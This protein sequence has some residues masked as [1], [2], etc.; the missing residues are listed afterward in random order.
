M[1]GTYMYICTFIQYVYSQQDAFST[2]FA[3]VMDAQQ[4][5]EAR[6]SRRR[7]RE[8][9]NRASESAEQRQ[10]R[11]VRRRVRDRARCVAQSAAQ[12]ETAL[13][14]GRERLTNETTES[15]ELRV[16]GMRL[17]RPSETQE[18]REAHLQ[19]MR[20][21][22]ASETPDE[23]EARLQQMRLNQEGRL[24]NESQEERE[25]RLQ[26]MRLNQEGR[27][28][29]ES[30]EERES[31]LQ[32]MRLNQEGRL[33][34]ESQEEREARLQQ[35]RL[36]Q[37]GRVANESQEERE[38]RLQ[39]MSLYRQCRL[40][41]EPPEDA[42]RRRKPGDQQP[43]EIVLTS[44]TK[45][46]ASPKKFASRAGPSTPNKLTLKNI[47][48][49]A[50][51]QSVTVVAKV[52]KAAPPQTIKTKD[53]R[54]M[55]KQDCSIGDCDR[56]IHVVSWEKDVGSLAEGSSYKLVNVSVHIYDDLRYLSVG[57]NCEIVRIDQ[58]GEVVEDDADEDQ[59]C[60]GNY[61]VEGDIDD[62]FYCDEYFGCT[63]CNKKLAVNDAIG[64]CSKCG[65]TVKIKKALKCAN[66]C[67]LVCDKNSTSHNL[68]LFNEVIFD[69][70]EGIQGDNI[71]QRLMQVEE[72]KFYVNKRHSLLSKK[73]VIVFTTSLLVVTL[74][75]L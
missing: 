49:V 13:Q 20:E 23:R 9:R 10:A 14:Q 34:N 51:G 35:M 72:T 67:I 26:Q 12:C 24:T 15:R 3:H 2:V 74:Y 38:S 42:L 46:D 60:V 11:L 6:L 18:E 39:Q 70:L 54:Q 57:S 8:S 45:V 69:L 73:G 55:T 21:R 31:R 27:V 75:C 32:Q 40:A 65:L 43:P 64:E 61:I 19:Q 28:A 37:E 25:A 58:I 36:N 4:K 5:R 16:L 7:E 53:G 50:V 30:Q 66:A 68:T 71:K 63:P 48:D 56:C 29:N 1:L 62:V 33:T 22:R 41:T 44:R 47:D 59:C 52:V 17:R